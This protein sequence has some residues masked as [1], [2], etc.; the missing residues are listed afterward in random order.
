LLRARV[1]EAWKVVSAR[2]GDQTLATDERGTVDISSLTGKQTIRFLV[3][4]N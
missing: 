1:P 4:P 3:G 2:A